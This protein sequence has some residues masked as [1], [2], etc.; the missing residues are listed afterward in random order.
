MGEIKKNIFNYGS[1][2]A[3]LTK[4][5]KLLNKKQILKKIKIK[6]LNKYF[7]IT[8]HPITLEKKIQKNILK[9][10]LIVW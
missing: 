2:G 10:Y 4:N 5:T 6:N 9:I 3:Y 7:V 8:F 1:L